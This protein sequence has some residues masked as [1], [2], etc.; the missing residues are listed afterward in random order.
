MVQLESAPSGQITLKPEDIL[1]PGEI[2]Q[3]CPGGYPSSLRRISQGPNTG[4]HTIKFS[5]NLRDGG[6]FPSQ[7]QAVD[8]GGGPAPVA[9]T[10]DGAAYAFPV[11]TPG[12]GGFGNFVAVL[13]ECEGV[14]FITLYAHLTSA[15]IP[16]GGPTKVTKE[17]S[18][19][20]SGRSGT[21]GDG[22]HLHY[23]IISQGSA[24]NIT[25]WLAR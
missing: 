18:I 16:L 4:T 14:K 23:E 5:V 22:L 10:H 24:F 19:G 25:S 17:Q 8:F 15:S 20:L 12:L 6:V 13:A 7:N 3:S 9:A 21:L 1:P 2:P 11:G